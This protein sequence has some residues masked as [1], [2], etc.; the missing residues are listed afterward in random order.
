MGSGWAMADSEQPQAGENPDDIGRG[1]PGGPRPHLLAGPSIC[2]NTRTTSITRTGVVSIWMPLSIAGSTGSL[3]S[4]A[5]ASCCSLNHRRGARFHR[6][7]VVASAVEIPS[8]SVRQQRH[9]GRIPSTRCNQ[10]PAHLRGRVR[11]HLQDMG[12]DSHPPA[13]G[14]P[15]SE[16]TCAPRSAPPPM[17]S[18][19]RASALLRRRCRAAPMRPTT[20]SQVGHVRSII[21]VKNIT[22][23]RAHR[24][25]QVKCQF[26]VVVFT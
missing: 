17:L 10:K 12:S 20:S 3:R 24:T 23:G 25:F 1:L 4:N 22:S 16:L 13:R 18:L 15:L 14:K 26:Q 9:A 6:A 11:L 7:P 8:S 2:G 5:S 21:C 19:S